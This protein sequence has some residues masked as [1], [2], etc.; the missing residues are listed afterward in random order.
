MDIAPCMLAALL[1]P[2]LPAWNQMHPLLVHFPIALAFVVPLFL[3]AALVFRRARLAALVTAAVLAVIAAGGAIAAVESGEATK[4]LTEAAIDRAPGA[5]SVLDRHEDLG[6]LA[7]NLLVLMAAGTIVGALAWWRWGAAAER[8]TGAGRAALPVG[9]VV[10]LLGQVGACLVVANAG[11]EGGRLV[12]EFGIR[13]WPGATAP[14]GE[15]ADDRHARGAVAPAPIATI[16]LPLPDAEKPV[17]MPGLHNLVAFTPTLISGGLPE[18]DEAF[19]TLAAMGIRTVISVDGAATDVERA[20]AHGLRYVHMP[21]TYAGFDDQRA[22]ELARAVRDLPGP[23]YI[24]CHHGKHRSAGAAASVAVTLGQLSNDQAV[25]RMK[26]SGTAPG[27]AGLYA[28][29]RN[30]SP[31]NAARLD[32]VSASFPERIEPEG[33]VRSM[34]EIDILHDHIRAS[35]KAGWATGDAAPK[36]E[37]G[38]PINAV[39]SAARLADIYRNLLTNPRVMAKPQEFQDW[40]RRSGDEAS[41]LEAGLLAGL[42]SEALN[43]RAA[44]VAASC[45]QCHVKYRD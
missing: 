20:R 15:D 31:S 17:D 30:A 34:V 32:T 37:D 9:G 5:P 3:V 4:E 24:H 43:A 18:G 10:L 45:K 2:P 44:A 25:A 14:T 1:P 40:T 19:A 21:I 23:I 6:E 41:E 8:A 26:I 36:G 33:L 27:Y 42:S 11:H 16:P 29:A 7:R 13:A 39:A 35:M 22:L 28:C 38:Q 12:H